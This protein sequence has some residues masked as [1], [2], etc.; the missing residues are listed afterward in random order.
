MIGLHRPDR[1]HIPPPYD[2]A[3][4]VGA[5]LLAIATLIGLLY[6]YLKV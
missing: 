1:T 3:P 2:L 4:L 6:T 5:F